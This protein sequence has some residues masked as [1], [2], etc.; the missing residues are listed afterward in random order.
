M[1]HP[2]IP[3]D[4]GHRRS[5]SYA[6][7]MRTGELRQYAGAATDNASP[8]PGARQQAMRSNGFGDRTCVAAPHDVWRQPQ[9]GRRQRY[10]EASGERLAASLPAEPLLECVT[11]VRP[12]PCG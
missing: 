8:S 6:I 2:A 1:D 11:I 10:R 7:G 3:Y 5:Q 12:S 4:M 9:D